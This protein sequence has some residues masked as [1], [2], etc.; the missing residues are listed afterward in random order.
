MDFVLPRMCEE[1]KLTKWFCWFL[2]V[3]WNTLVH[4]MRTNKHNNYCDIY[5][6]MRIWCSVHDRGN[7]RNK[8]IAKHKIIWKMWHSLWSERIFNSGIQTWSV[9]N[10]SKF[11]NQQSMALQVG[12]IIR[13]NSFNEFR[14]N[15]LCLCMG[16]RF[17]A[18]PARSVC[19]WWMRASCKCAPNWI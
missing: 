17:D 9:K 16:N 5:R 13:I 2:H 10:P 8:F 7:Q 3:S 11:Q 15:A 1:K 18:V 19:V 6:E 4:I 14:M 12:L